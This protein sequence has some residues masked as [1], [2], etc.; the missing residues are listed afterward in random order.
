MAGIATIPG[1]FKSVFSSERGWHFTAEIIVGD[2]VH[3]AT[4]LA[5]RLVRGHDWE[6]SPAVGCFVDKGDAK[7]V[8]EEDRLAVSL[9]P[10]RFTRSRAELE[11]AVSAFGFSGTVTAHLTPKGRWIVHLERMKGLRYSPEEVSAVRCAIRES[12]RRAA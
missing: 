9:G 4:S 3:T 8:L 6:F 2:C 11:V 7:R 12:A 5:R 10:V 1:T